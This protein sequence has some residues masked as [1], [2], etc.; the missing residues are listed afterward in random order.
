[1][2]HRDENVDTKAAFKRSDNNNRGNK[3]KERLKKGSGGTWEKEF[4]IEVG[5]ATQYERK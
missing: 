4:V 1:V 5:V 2:R 3:R